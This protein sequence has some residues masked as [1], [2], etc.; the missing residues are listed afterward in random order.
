M[1]HSILVIGDEA[2]LRSNL[3]SVLHEAGFAV[4]AA[5]DY[6]G[7]LF[8][9][10]GF[11][12]D[13]VIMD[14]VL[15]DEDAVE[16]CYQLRNSCGIPVILLGRDSSKEAWRRVTEAEIDSYVLKPVTSRELIARVK[17][18]LRRYETQQ[19]PDLQSRLKLF[20]SDVGSTQEEEK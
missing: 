18:V 8:N 14:E 13:L 7:M 3:A 4:T 12:P 5:P 10:N 16:V 1:T 9:Q 17:A 19:I 15:L 6:H 11:K 2:T 20:R